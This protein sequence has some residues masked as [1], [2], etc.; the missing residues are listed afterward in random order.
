MRANG[1]R[2]PA[3]ATSRSAP[4]A[5]PTI[6]NA[7]EAYRQRSPETPRGL[8]SFATRVFAGGVC[9]RLPRQG[10]SVRTESCGFP[11]TKVRF[12]HGVTGGTCATPGPSGRFA[13]TRR[14][15]AGAHRGRRATPW[16]GTQGGGDRRLAYR[17]PPHDPCAVGRD[18]R[19]GGRLAGRH[20]AV[21]RF[22]GE[23]FRRR[24]SAALMWPVLSVGRPGRSD[25]EGGSDE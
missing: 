11:T 13:R 1:G 3:V 19:I 2:S 21:L 23:A 10:V 20:P 14:W 8:R 15:S 25:P 9:G 6:S 24:S 22:P 4:T 17:I 5:I 7:G 12:S 16:G 18:P